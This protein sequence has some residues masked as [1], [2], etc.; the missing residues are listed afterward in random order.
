VVI[1]IDGILSLIH[2][3][4]HR[5]EEINV[6]LLLRK[7]WW[8]NRTLLTWTYLSQRIAS[9]WHVLCTGIDS[10]NLC[11]DTTW[12]VKVWW[13]YMLKLCNNG[14][15]LIEVACTKCCPEIYY[16]LAWL[17]FQDEYSLWECR[18]ISGQKMTSSGS[19]LQVK[20]IIDSN[21][22]RVLPINDDNKCT[23][24]ARSYGGTGT[25]IA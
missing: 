19:K 25:T 1:K 21:I 14:V 8:F 13:H 22:E 7:F 2:I 16:Y 15:I 20:K 5:S 9:F 17:L 6:L 12:L 4:C 24:L 10:H 23:W 18:F 3:T 11:K